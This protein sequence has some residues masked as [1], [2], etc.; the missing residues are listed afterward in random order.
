MTTADVK[1]CVEFLNAK[2]AMPAGWQQEFTEYLT[3]MIRDTPDGRL[4]DHVSDLYWE[5][6]QKLVDGVIED[7][8]SGFIARMAEFVKSVTNACPHSE[9]VLNPG[10]AAVTLYASRFST[11][12]LVNFDVSVSY[13][14]GKAEFPWA[15]LAEAAFTGDCV[16]E[17]Y[18]RPEFQTVQHEGATSG[19]EAEAGRS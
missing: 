13:R 5:A 1:T 6:V 2:Y 15:L 14:G 18:N 8:R 16:A 4:D 12:G 17:L 10:L 3:P 7:Y 19:T 11:M 9:Y